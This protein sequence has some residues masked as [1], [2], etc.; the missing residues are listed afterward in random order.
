MIIGVQLLNGKRW[1]AIN[2]NS[3]AL[4]CP[5]GSR[6]LL[7]SL[8]FWKDTNC[9]IQ[10]APVAGESG[11]TYNL[12]GIAGSA[13]PVTDLGKIKRGKC[14]GVIEAKLLHQS[15]LDTEHTKSVANDKTGV[16]LNEYFIHVETKLWI[17]FT[18]S[19][20]GSEM[21][22]IPGGNFHFEKKA[23]HLSESNLINPLRETLIFPHTA[24]FIHNIHV[25]FHPCNNKW[26]V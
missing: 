4:T 26:R 10:C 12:P 8:S 6:W 1:N 16:A 2:K 3:E 24:F 13:F 5:K 17:Y 19:L 9:L 7:V 25:S 23:A 22:Q 21:L 20:L 14:P 15:S 11:W 18:E